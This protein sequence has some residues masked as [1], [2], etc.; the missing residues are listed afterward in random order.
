MPRQAAR[1]SAGHPYAG[2][3]ARLPAIGPLLEKT[4][5]AAGLEPPRS[6]IAVTTYSM[7]NELL[8]TGR[9]LS[10][11]PG[12]LVRL[13]RKHSVLKALLELPN[14]RMP[15]AIIT[16]KNRSLS[17]LAQLFIEDLRA[18]TRPLAKSWTGRSPGFS[19]RRIRSI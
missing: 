1:P 8:A 7:R 15:I 2:Q 11:A 12:V 5:R 18:F 14:T 6:T 9:Y 3:D 10:A 17:P 4:F 13:P 19:P 16:L